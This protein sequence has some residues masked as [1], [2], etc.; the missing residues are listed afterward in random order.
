MNGIKT[1]T[2]VEQHNPKL[3]VQSFSALHDQY[4][5]RLLNSM[6][7]LTKNRDIAE[8][9]TAT[10]FASALKNLASFHGRSSFYTWLHAIAMNVAKISWCRRRTV[11]LESILV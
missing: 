5:N 11:S 7:G 9:I 1:S 6:T 10:A 4:R 2:P 3:D 8:D